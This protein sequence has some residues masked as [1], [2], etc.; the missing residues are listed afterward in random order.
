MVYIASLAAHDAGRLE[1]TG[2]RGALLTRRA[3]L[4]D[5]PDAASVL[6]RLASPRYMRHPSCVVPLPKRSRGDLSTAELAV[7][8]AR[9]ALARQAGFD[10]HSVGALIYVHA[11]PD[12]RTTDS[13]A[14][15]LQCD[16]DL[17][18]ACAFSVSQ[19][20]NTAALIAL[21]MAAGLIEGPEAADA[22]LLVAADK[23]VFGKA[24]HAARR[25]VWSD[26]A[27]AAVLSREAAYGWRI[28]AIE[29]GH[30]ATSFDAGHHWPPDAV[31]AFAERVAAAL[32]RCLAQAGT[33]PDRL[34]AV[35][36][37]SADPAFVATVHPLAGLERVAAPLRRQGLRA[38]FVACADPLAGLAACEAQIA[39]G[40]PVLTWS[41]GDNGEFAC[42]VTTR[43]G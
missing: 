8:V 11:T 28:D 26:V 2:L 7:Q 37:V 39:P 10:P 30:V 43:I 14:G 19:A 5:C 35:L 16:L 36:P 25:M 15:R 4:G 1:S 42:I 13:T 31:D 3:N 21:D 34:A 12:A 20:H 29:L 9:Q 40:N 41:H 24:P 18:R 33:L 38:P 32:S 6:R 17:K 23:L 27:A 22:V